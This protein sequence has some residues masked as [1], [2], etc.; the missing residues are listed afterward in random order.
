MNSTNCEIKAFQTLSQKRESCLQFLQDDEKEKK[1]DQINLEKRFY[2]LV[3]WEESITV[4]WQH[5]KN[6]LKKGDPS[7][8]LQQARSDQNSPIS[9]QTFL[10]SF[11][12]VYEETMLHEMYENELFEK[13]TINKS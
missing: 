13:V 10:E 12:D 7:F 3:E 5:L 8:S 9:L 2:E 4:L 11:V 6:D 1:L